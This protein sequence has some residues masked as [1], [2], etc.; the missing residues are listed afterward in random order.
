[1]VSGEPTPQIA[2]TAQSLTISGLTAGTTYYFAIK[3]SDEVLNESLLSNV[4][5]AATA[6]TTGASADLSITKLDSPDP[7]IAGDTLTYSITVTNN[8]PD[9]AENVVV[10]DTLPLA[11]TS[12]SLTS[13][14]GA[15]SIFPCNLGVIASS[16]SASITVT[17]PID[18]STIGTITNIASVLS[19]TDDPIALNNI[20]TQETTAL[21]S[22]EPE[23]IPSSEGR[24][25]P[26]TV[27]FSGR[28]FP[29]AKIFIVDKD[30]RFETMVNQNIVADENGTFQVN[31]V[32]VSQGLHSFGL[33][34]KD[35]DN[36]ATQTKF[37]N[38]G[39]LENDF[40]VKDI[41]VPPT[42]GLPQ[43]LVSRGETAIIAGNASPDNSVIVEIDDI[44]KKEANVEKDGSYKVAVDTGIL[45]FG[46]HRVRV[47]QVDTGQKRESDYSPTNTLVISRLTLPKTDLNGDGA[48]NIKDWSMFLSNWG[49]K[50]KN[51][52]KIIDLNDDGKIDISDFSIFIRTIKK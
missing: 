49:A 32:S 6:A 12:P 26:I 18:S 37:F 42:I 16:Q 43:R 35:R 38:I 9:N 33:L 25:K 5:S 51:Q 27:A 39:T 3:T 40:I 46:T 36:H 34:I 2:G 15:C 4:V 45:E 30:V 17:S 29:N 41:L 31:F 14:Q 47:K 8:G 50:D 7:V 48:V 11:L 23:P 28:A 10:S 24:A 20:S 1:Q 13:S 21:S 44:I 52:K 19:D 22:P